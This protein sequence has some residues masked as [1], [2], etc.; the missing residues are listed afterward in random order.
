MLKL[1]QVIVKF[2]GHQTD[3]YAMYAD[4]YNRYSAEVLK[5]NIGPY[6]DKAQD[7]RLI[8]LS[9]QSEQMHEAMLSEIERIAGQKRPANMPAEIWA[10]NPNFKWA[11]FAVVTAMIETILPATIIDSIGLYT[12]MRFIGWGDV[13]HFEVPSNALMTVS[14]GNTLAA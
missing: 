4:Y 3:C 9:E 8:S 13:P 12:D 6:N 10:S 5:K 1:S 11:T 14:M 2:S 7:G